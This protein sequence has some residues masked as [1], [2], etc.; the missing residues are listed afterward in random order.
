NAD[1]SFLPLDVTTAAAGAGRAGS[2]VD[3]GK[4]DAI[5]EI[6]NLLKLELKLVKSAEPLLQ[7]FLYR[8]RTVEGDQ[9]RLPHGIGCVEAHQR[10]EVAAARSSEEQAHTRGQV[11]GR[12]LL[13]HTVS[14]P[15]PACRGGGTPQTS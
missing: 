15:C 9:R 7:A 2:L 4:G 11:G 12:G 14:I 5:A 6:E 8:R 10:V 13:G 3:H 1:Q